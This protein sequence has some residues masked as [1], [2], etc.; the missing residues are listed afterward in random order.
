MT[1]RRQLLAVGLLALALLGLTIARP[2]AA[3][4]APAPAATPGVAALVDGAAVPLALYRRELGIY[5]ATLP[6][7]GLDRRVRDIAAADRALRQAV[8]ETIIAREAARRH[9]T[10]SP[11]AIRAELA[12]M[13]ADAGGAASFASITR[14]EGLTPSDQEAMARTAVLDD[15][16][17]RRTGD[18]HLIDRLY[19]QARVV[20]F[21]GPR[22]GLSG[23]AP[24]PQAGHPAPELAATTL[25]GGRSVSLAAL[26]GSPVILTFWSTAC[27]W[28]R[29]E[30]SLLDRYALNH[31]E[32]RVIALDIGDAP[33]AAASFM[34]DLGLHLAVWLDPDGA[35]ARTYGLSGLPETVAIDRQGVIRATAIGALDGAAALQRL[36]LAATG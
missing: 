8:A 19:A 9:L 11:A 23:P 24:A 4:G 12:G 27:T 34:H 21:V 15:L 14:G 2:A 22:A 29:A 30:M 10:A 17:V 1:P 5:R 13:R 20:V 33:D 25:Q 36:G 35:S 6:S 31:P 26:Q 16:L 7:G 32:V 28:C 3:P 18:A